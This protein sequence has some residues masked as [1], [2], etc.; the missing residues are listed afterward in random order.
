MLSLTRIRPKAQLKDSSDGN[1][2]RKANVKYRFP[3]QVSLDRS[4]NPALKQGWLL[5][6]G[7]KPGSRM[8][9]QV[10][11]FV[12]F[13]PDQYSNNAHTTISRYT[14]NTFKLRYI[15]HV[16]FIFTFST[17]HTYELSIAT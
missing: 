15:N 14:V 1:P 2:E 5:S 8:E 17:E 11:D 13:M 16:F 3:N 7:I 9:P 4:L 12:Q 10:S 6:L